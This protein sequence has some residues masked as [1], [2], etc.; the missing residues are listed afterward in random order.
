[1]DYLRLVQSPPL[2]FQSSVFIR[3]ESSLKRTLKLGLESPNNPRIHPVH[4][5]VTF[6]GVL[7]A[8]CANGAGVVKDIDSVGVWLVDAGVEGGMQVSGLSN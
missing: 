1:M 7:N 8:P 5:P 6:T 4:L 2:K 3:R